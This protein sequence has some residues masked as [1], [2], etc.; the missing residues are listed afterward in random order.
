MTTTHKEMIELLN[1]ANCLALLQLPRG[2][3]NANEIEQK[4]EE[5]KQY[6]T[7][8]VEAA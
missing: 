1:K 2:N 7:T 4:F 6:L 5:L 3:P 8:V